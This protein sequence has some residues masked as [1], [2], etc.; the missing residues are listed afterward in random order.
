MNKRELQIRLGVTIALICILLFLL[1]KVFAQTSQAYK[2]GFNDGILSGRSEAYHL[3]KKYSGSQAAE[4][5]FN[6]LLNAEIDK[7][8]NEHKHK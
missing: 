6:I 7:V 8:K 5:Y 1:S 3:L 2:D 4:N